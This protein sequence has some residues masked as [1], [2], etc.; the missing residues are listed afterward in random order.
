MRSPVSRGQERRAHPDAIGAELQHVKAREVFEVGNVGDLVVQQ[1]ELLQL[2]Q[3]LQT[4]HLPQQV[5]RNVQLPVADEHRIQNISMLLQEAHNP[6]Y[7]AYKATK[8]DRPVRTL[9]WLVQVDTCVL[10][11]INKTLR[12]A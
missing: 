1:E 2:R 12:N 4:F 10:Y 8:E 3:T 7:R 5:E 6:S 9:A 11:Y